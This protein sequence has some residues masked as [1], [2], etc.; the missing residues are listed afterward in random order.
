MKKTSHIMLSVLVLLSIL[1][2]YDTSAQFKV[3][4]LYINDEE[5]PLQQGETVRDVFDSL[6][7]IEEVQEIRFIGTVTN[8]N[9]EINS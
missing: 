6:P 2:A 4:G 5:I 8:D 7:R 1:V 3:S 9:I